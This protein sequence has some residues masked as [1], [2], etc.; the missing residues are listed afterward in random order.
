MGGDAGH[1]DSERGRSRRTC[2]RRISR[3]TERKGCRTHASSPAHCANRH[4]FRRAAR[5]LGSGS[6]RPRSRRVPQAGPPSSTGWRPTG[7]RCRT[8][9]RAPTSPRAGPG[10][11]ARPAP[12][13]PADRHP[14]RRRRPRRRP[15]HRGGSTLVLRL[16]PRTPRW[17]RCSATCC[18]VA[19][20]VRG[21]SG[22]PRRRA[23]R[24][25]RP[26]STAWPARSGSTTASRSRAA[27]WH[28]RRLGVIGSPG[29]AGRGA[30]P[31][32]EPR[33]IGHQPVAGRRRRRPRARLRHRRDPLL[34]GQG[35]LDA[36]LGA[37]ALRVVEGVD[38]L[39]RARRCCARTLPVCGL[40]SC[41]RP[42]APPAPARSTRSARSL[43][44]REHGAGARRRRLGRG[45]GALPG[46]PGLLDGVELADLFCTDAHKWLLTAFDACC[47]GCATRRRCP[48]PCRS[49]RVPARRRRAGRRS[50]TATGRSRWA[51]ASGAEAVDGAAHPRAR[52]PARAHPRPRGA[53]RW[54]WPG[55]SRPSPASPW[56]RRLARAGVPAPR[57][58]RP[59]GG[60]PCHRAA[61]DGERLGRR[62]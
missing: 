14:A 32:L 43:V 41:A 17:P 18:R 30:A 44:A 36:G 21:C 57:H 5:P 16:L 23:P 54:S 22:R 11:T 7:R 46:A 15:R 28:N 12:R 19:W 31:Q 61:G 13:A 3:V 42:S 40:C 29:R 38:V 49:T 25:S 8:G 2:S 50:T 10:R 6:D 58:R 56:P 55:G 35:R 33:R 26:C 4:L 52:G 1:E 51:A 62:S 48:P 59:G 37:R 60:R 24:S 53:G 20:A 39:G 9:R 45:R 47:C 34:H 27:G